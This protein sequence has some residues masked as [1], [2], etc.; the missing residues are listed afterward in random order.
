MSYARLSTALLFLALLV[1]AT[2]LQPAAAYA[3]VS[4]GGGAAGYHIFSADGQARYL[5]FVLVVAKILP[6][7][8]M[9]PKEFQPGAEY[10]Y[11]QD[12]SKAYAEDFILAPSDALKLPSDNVSDYDRFAHLA[13]DLA[14]PQPFPKMSQEI[15]WTY[16]V[17]TGDSQGKALDTTP[18]AWFAFLDKGHGA[19]LAWARKDIG[20]AYLSIEKDQSL[21]FVRSSLPAAGS[22]EVVAAR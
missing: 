20:D 12:K 8:I 10:W 9:L 21:L 17:Y 6:D 14:A 19:Q 15:E 18:E 4:A 16:T 22:L 2:V 1:T 3:Q 13:F 7:S 5:G 11:W